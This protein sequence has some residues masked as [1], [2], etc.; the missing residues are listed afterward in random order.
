MSQLSLLPE[1][2]LQHLSRSLPGQ[3]MQHSL[4]Y[5]VGRFCQMGACL[6]ALIDAPTGTALIL[7]KPV[8]RT[9][10]V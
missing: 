10:P 3:P 4:L 7:P 8:E 6:A 5:G 2:D 9:Q 1:S